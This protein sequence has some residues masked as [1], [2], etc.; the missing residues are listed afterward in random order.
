MLHLHAC[1]LSSAA[2]TC[3][4]HYATPGLLHPPSNIQLL[5]SN[6]F[7][8]TILVPSF[9]EIG[10]FRLCFFE[11][12]STCAGITWHARRDTFLSQNS[13]NILS[14]LSIFK[15]NIG[16]TNNKFMPDNFYPVISYPRVQD[17]SDELSCTVWSLVTVR[18]LLF[19]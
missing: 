1:K 14:I 5:I 7:F 13:R 19:V 10:R 15:Y 4:T 12:N 18:S 2:R 3:L 8:K 11:R 16:R 9:I 6:I 17:E